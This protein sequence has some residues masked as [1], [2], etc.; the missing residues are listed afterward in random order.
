MIKFTNVK[1]GGGQDR[2]PLSGFTLVELLVVIAIIGM[3]IALLLPAVQAAREAARRM[4]CTNH[5]K[6]YVLTIHNYHDVHDRVPPSNSLR[7]AFWRNDPPAGAEQWGMNP[8]WGGNSNWSTHF[9]ILPFMEQSARYEAIRSVTHIQAMEFFATTRCEPGVRWAPVIEKVPSFLCPSDGNS[10]TCPY[11]ATN[12]VTSR[13]DRSNNVNPA[14]PAL[15]SAAPASTSNE[16]LSMARSMFAVQYWNWDNERNFGYCSDGLSNTIAISEAVAAVER[17]HRHFKG[18]VF[19]VSGPANNAMTNCGRGAMVDGSDVPSNRVLIWSNANG[20]AIANWRPT[21]AEPLTPPLRAWRWADGQP[22][23]T[24]FTTTLPPNQGSCIQNADA[25]GANS[26]GNYTAQSWHSGGVNVGF[27]DGSVR[28]V[29]D[30]VDVNGGNF[31]AAGTPTSLPTTGPSSW[32]VWG[33]LGTPNGG[34]SV[35]L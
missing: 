32:G 27:F 25:L 6:Q 10:S 8:S 23:F 16:A 2:Q 17:N 21:D 19:V 3:L 20:T 28:F 1:L 11:G 33:G 35:S 30:T 7:G 4:Q 24:G 26:F 15:G 14:V 29:S 18:A 13:G 12:I 5:M 34:E 31:T 22:L 9:W